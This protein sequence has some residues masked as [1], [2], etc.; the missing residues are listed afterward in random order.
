VVKYELAMPIR[1][2]TPK[3]SQSQR[4]RR[5]SATFARHRL[6][7]LELLAGKWDGETARYFRDTLKLTTSNARRILRSLVDDGLIVPTRFE[8][9]E[10]R[11]SAYRI[12]GP[13]R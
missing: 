7:V 13:R 9:H 5:R 3:T 2:L 12:W 4:A 11:E 10:R 1:R 6:R 8:K